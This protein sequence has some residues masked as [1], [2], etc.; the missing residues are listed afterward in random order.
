MYGTVFRE[1]LP[2]G[3]GYPVAGKVEEEDPPEED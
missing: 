1:W 3:R 2:A